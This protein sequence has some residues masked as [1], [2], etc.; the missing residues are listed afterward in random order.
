MPGAMVH[1]GNKRQ[2]IAPSSRALAGMP[3]TYAAASNDPYHRCCVLVK[4]ASL[5]AQVNA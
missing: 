3:E 4:Y 1:A 2:V 5:T